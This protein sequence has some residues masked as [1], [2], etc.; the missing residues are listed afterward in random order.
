MKTWA[1]FE[2]GITISITHNVIN[3]CSNVV[4]GHHDTIMHLSTACSI[5]LVAT[6]AVLLTN[7]IKT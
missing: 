3:D 2:N 4:A 7:V 6:I 5:R 1:E